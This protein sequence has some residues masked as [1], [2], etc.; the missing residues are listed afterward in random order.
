V[1]YLAGSISETL[2][3]NFIGKATSPRHR[4]SAI[5]LSMHR[6]ASVLDLVGQLDMRLNNPLQI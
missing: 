5:F 2:K 4:K 1:V 3:I 6:W